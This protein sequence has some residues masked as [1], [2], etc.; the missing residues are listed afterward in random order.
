MGF[1]QRVMVSQLVPAALV[2]VLGAAV[3]LG[4]S[5]LESRLADYFSRQDALA[6]EVAEMYAQGLQ[7][8]Q[9]LRNIAL[10]PAN[11][12]GYENLENAAKAYDKAA[13]GAAAAAGDEHKK[14]LASMA[15]MRRKLAQ[16]QAEV[17]T[18]APQDAAAAIQLITKQET[19][20]WRELRG[21]LIELK[22]SSA[23]DKEAA[24]VE[25][26]A[27]MAKARWW[28]LGLVALCLVVCVF[29]Q[30]NLRVALRSELGGDPALA[31]DVL[32]RVAEGDLLAEVPVAQGDSHSMMSALARTRDSLRALVSDVNLSAQ[33]ISTATGEIAAGN[34][35]LSNRTEQQA[36][37]LQETA[38]SMEQL[39]STVRHNADSADE[40]SK[41]AHQ[42][43]SVAAEGGAVV[44]QVVLT[45]DAICAQS[46][47]ISDITS[48]ID[49]I[50]FQTNILALNAAVEAARA[51]EQGRGFAVVASEVRSLAQRSAQAAREIK[52]LIAE[53]VEKVE[54]GSQQVQQAGQT[55]EALVQ[56]VQRVSGLIGEISAATREQSSGLSQVSQAVGQLD[57]VTQQNAALVE[58]STAAA[59]SLNEQAAR[60]GGL[61]GVFKLR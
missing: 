23:A 40:A 10:D 25:A 14:K 9:A 42:A 8:G 33:S 41:L 39:A 56:Q 44:Q 29:L 50:A 18:L 61:V 15:E 38:A 1:M 20:A 7:M 46:R 27:A 59:M 28:T 30:L 17:V 12:K 53:N 49:S 60:L 11:K 45:M 32:E 24:R 34:Q 35:D 6:S 58:Q 2:V 36:S 19:P 43:S 47:K 21:E 3:A 51:G 4:T 22:K 13:Q 52:S 57:E 54:G 48:V 31:R 16:V 37:S 5:G 26:G 55:M